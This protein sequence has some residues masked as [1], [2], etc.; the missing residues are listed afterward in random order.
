MLDVI[1]IAT[2]LGSISLVWLLL[3]WCGRQVEAEE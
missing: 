3:R 2:L 1:M